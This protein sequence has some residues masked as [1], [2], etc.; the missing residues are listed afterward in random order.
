MLELSIK[1][2]FYIR[3]FIVPRLCV[4]VVSSFHT[5]RLLHTSPLPQH[6]IVSIFTRF[7]RILVRSINLKSFG[8]MFILV[9]D[10]LLFSYCLISVFYLSNV[11]VIYAQ[12]VTLGWLELNK[13]QFSSF[14]TVISIWTRSKK[15]RVRWNERSFYLFVVISIFIGRRIRYMYTRNSQHSFEFVSLYV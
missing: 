7:L 13:M 10:V 15:T 8:T 3:Y 6:H 4:T 2:L 11:V 12:T 14:S 9:L 1:N 5:S